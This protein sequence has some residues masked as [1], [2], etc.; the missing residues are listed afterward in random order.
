MVTQ[1]AYLLEFIKHPKTR[2]SV[3]YCFKLRNWIKWIKCGIY[4]HDDFRTSNDLLDDFNI[5]HI[6]SHPRLRH[7]GLQDCKFFAHNDLFQFRPKTDNITKISRF[8]LN[9]FWFLKWA[10]RG[11]NSFDKPSHRTANEDKLYSRIRTF[12]TLSF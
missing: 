12:Q 3:F 9:T 5:R 1:F 2:T 7:H 6:I 8:V 4:W 10:F 11:Q